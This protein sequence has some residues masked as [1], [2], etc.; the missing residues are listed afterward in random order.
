MRQAISNGEFILYYQPKLNLTSGSVTGA[1]ALL[2]WQSPRT[3]LV[4][5]GEFIPI[6]EETGM[7]HEVGRW[8]MRK[9]IEDMLYWRDSGMTPLPVA[10]NVSP[11]QLSDPGFYDELR[12]AIEI[13]PF[14]AAN[15]EIEITESL[16]MVDL[17]RSIS[18]LRRIR[19][20]GVTVA[21]DDFGTGF[22]SLS[23]LAKLPVNTLKVDR[24]FIL[25]LGTAEGLEMVSTITRVA[26]ALNLKVVA[27]GV[28][29]EDQLR[30]LK[31][32]HCEEVQGYLFSK[33]LPAKD[34]AVNFL[35]VAQ[36]L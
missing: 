21:I 16:V 15:L 1:E 2:R 34:Y 4:P 10:V 13:D 9:A 3:G 23:Y 25:E 28:E 22:S 12:H 19:N 32:L 17:E 33:P 35:A 27:E 7:I 6:L 11:L 5:P 26:H 29:T 18:V 30:Q 24:S 20:L 8:A 14:L 36:V 31:A